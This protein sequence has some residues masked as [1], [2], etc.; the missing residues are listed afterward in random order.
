MIVAEFV[1]TV[2]LLI[3]KIQDTLP[4]KE[5]EE[6]YP[7]QEKLADLAWTLGWRHPPFRINY[8]CNIPQR[9][10]LRSVEILEPMGASLH[11]RLLDSS[12]LGVPE[13]GSPM[14]PK[15]WFPFSSEERHQFIATL[16][17]WQRSARA[18]LALSEIAVPSGAALVARGTPDSPASKSEK[19][20]KRLR[21]PSEIAMAAYRLS[22]VTGSTQVEIAKALTKAF[23]VPAEQ[24]QVSRWIKQV[25]RYVEAGNVLPEPPRTAK[26]AKSID[27]KRLDLGPR[28]DHTTPRQRQRESDDE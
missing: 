9:R 20:S 25:R 16:K 18:K 8:Q 3:G 24:N 5:F 27:P 12:P 13:D 2:D 21:Q 4:N 7:Y 22:L 26:P 1:T 19:E 17:A 14:T 28:T 15:Y 10:E 11:M 6:T 23:R